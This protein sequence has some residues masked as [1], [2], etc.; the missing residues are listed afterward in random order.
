M[1]AL[2]PHRTAVA[3]IRSVS[4]PPPHP[5]RS[6]WALAAAALVVAGCSGGSAAPSGPAGGQA[7]PP[8]SVGVI[9]VQAGSLGLSA[10]LPG[11]L[12]SSRVAQ[13]R[14]RV[15]G[16]VQKRSFQEGAAVKAGQPLFEID[17][18]PYRA[19][20]ASAEAGKARA[21][22]VLAQALA[23]LERNRP[24]AQ[25]RAISDQDWITIQSTHKQ[26]VAD[27]ASAEAAVQQ[28]RLNVEYAQ[29][30]SPISGR[31]GRALVTEGALVSQTEAT[32]LALV[33]QVDPLYVNFTQSATESLRLRRAIESGELKSSTAGQV[34]LLLDDG[35]E[36]PVPGKLLF[37]DVTVDPNSG[38]VM[39]RA[40]IPNPKGVLLP[41]LYVK[42]RL[43]QA[44]SD[45]A[46]LVP[47]QAVTRGVSEDTVL[48]VTPDHQVAPRAVKLGGARGSNQ[49]VVLDGLKPGEQ[50][51]VD[52][53]QK[54][55][56]KSPVT[57]VPWAAAP[58]APAAASSPAS[59]PVAGAGSTA[60]SH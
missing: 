2:T 38:Q 13:V 17:A 43:E 59:A 47:Q 23:T 55:R 4:A 60:S 39:L 26:A 3:A 33:Q 40:E 45:N 8:P 58:A 14:A 5:S 32:Q 12:E 7:P 18:A 22:V 41:G 28:A 54:I 31:I 6:F 52:G 42:V 1:L 36:Y 11:R 56:P 21:Q 44:R 48:V 15:T 35:S 20:L 53:F 49:W 25:A 50:V 30:R 9:T 24:L 16:I 29:V 27:L 46:I 10:E 19:T 34:R 37:T 57:P 51:V